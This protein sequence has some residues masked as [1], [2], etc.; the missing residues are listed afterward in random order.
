MASLFTAQEILD[1]ANGELGLPA[2]LF[3]PSAVDQTGRQLSAMI[4][5]IGDDLCRA[6]DWQF[7]QRTHIFVGDG[8]TAEFPLP[9]DYGRIVNQTLWATA[10]SMPQ[11]P[12][13]GP[14]SPQSWGWIKYGLLGLNTYFRY[15]VVGNKLNVYPVPGLGQ[16]F[17]F[18]YITKF[19][20]LAYP[21]TEDDPA[22]LRDLVTLPNDMPLF[23]RRLMISASKAQLWGQ[24][25]F[26]TTQVQ[27]E[28]NT[29]LLN[30]KGT[31]QGAPVL[32]LAGCR[33]PFYITTRNIPEGNWG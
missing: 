15:R 9:A 7:L 28:F 23:H 1:A 25:G 27:S 21:H 6:H 12:V 31:T 19:W 14:E 32:H 18:F 2:V 5:A 20:V 22:L 26:D 4:N 8:V 30:E 24:K 29:V 11:Q 3:G 17:T 16:E 13:G 33:D 10:G